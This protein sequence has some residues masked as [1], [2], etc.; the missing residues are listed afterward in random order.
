[1]LKK[2]LFSSTLGSQQYLIIERSG[3][4]ETST[5]DSRDNS[6]NRE[7]V[8]AYYVYLDIIAVTQT[9][10]LLLT[11]SVPHVESK[12][13]KAINKGSKTAAWMQDNAETV[14][15]KKVRISGF[16]IKAHFQN[17]NQLPYSI[18]RNI[19]KSLPFQRLW[20]KI[21]NLMAPRLVWKTRGW[22]STPSVATYFFSNSP[23]IKQ[24]V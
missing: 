13:N 9:A 18:S 20:C 14:S 24:Q 4:L 11:S 22:T 15:G 23:Q 17:Q 7:S 3:D 8:N 16:R 10:K 12:S 19:K 2:D 1:M 5:W 6:V 21:M